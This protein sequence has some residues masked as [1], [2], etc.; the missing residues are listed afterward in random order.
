MAKRP[1]SFQT[2]F[3]QIQEGRKSDPTLSSWSTGVTKTKTG[4]TQQATGQTTEKAKEVET[5]T[6]AET[7]KTGMAVPASGAPTT[8]TITSSWANPTTAPSYTGD[9]INQWANEFQAA[10]T[11]APTVQKAAGE[12]TAGLGTSQQEAIKAAEASQAAVEQGQTDYLKGLRGYLGADD[13]NLGM[14][15]KTSDME[16]QA[17]GIQDVLSQPST[18]NIA[19]LHSLLGAS[20]D[21]RLAALESGI[22][23]G[24]V[25]KLRGEATA[26]KSDL[27]SAEQARTR[28]L[29][30]YLT[31][32]QKAGQRLTE[33]EQ[34]IGLNEKG[35]KFSDSVIASINQQVND[36]MKQIAED[37]ARI[38]ET[39]PTLAKENFRAALPSMEKNLMT[40]FKDVFS[41]KRPVEEIEA[42]LGALDK[43]LDLI[44]THA[45]DM[46]KRWEG[47][48]TN[49]RNQVQSYKNALAEMKN[50]QQQQQNQTQELDPEFRGGNQ[51]SSQRPEGKTYGGGLQSP[52]KE[53]TPEQKAKGAVVGLQNPLLPSPVAKDNKKEG[54]GSRAGSSTTGRHETRAAKSK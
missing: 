34:K 47:L 5:K 54:G 22:Y 42:M 9:D 25:G 18:S 45:P 36:Q 12:A 15:T 17:A 14:T 43:N 40:T 35:E 38:A 20:Y 41:G 29:E 52:F 46:V 2:M 4:A 7:V 8:P 26:G 16:S 11:I 1:N 6:G 23:E 32:K 37:S 27:A 31:G 44:K 49:Y 33:A 39:Y 19:A 50:K 48:I 30:D 21:P 13:Y 3:S 53:A 10:N 28:T 24:E 51:S